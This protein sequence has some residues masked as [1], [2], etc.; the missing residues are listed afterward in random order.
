MA[1]VRS[2]ARGADDDDHGKNISKGRLRF[3]RRTGKNSVRRPQRTAFARMDPTVMAL[4]LAAA[5]LLFLCGALYLRTFGQADSPSFGSSSLSGLPAVEEAPIVGAKVANAVNGA[6]SGDGALGQRSG[7]RGAIARYVL[8]KDRLG[9]ARE[10]LRDNGADVREDDEL[11][12]VEVV[13]LT[14]SHGDIQIRL[15]PD[16]SPESVRYVR[17]VLASPE[18]CSPCN[19][20]RA[21]KP[22]IF[23][24]KI[25][26]KGVSANQELGKCPEDYLK[27]G[28]PPKRD[29]PP[30]DP[31]CGCHGPIMTR[32]M[33][34]WAGGGPGPDFFIDMYK[35][36]AD[37]WA[38]DHTVWGEI[39][40]EMSLAVVDKMFEL[41]ATN[42]GGMTFLDEHIH[43]DII[44]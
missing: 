7:V 29:C 33:V 39:L 43:F 38:N 40:D 5:C 16:L 25:V 26:K 36:P 41:P 22:G 9:N 42:R 10:G 2:R 1:G 21:E 27:D 14:T 6:D 19:F 8:E 20:Y 44:G 31:Q 3:R 15:R 13:T 24:G 12:L 11:G 4:L 35:K 30:H 34:G 23:Q 37:W 32:G 18:P 28:T 17:E